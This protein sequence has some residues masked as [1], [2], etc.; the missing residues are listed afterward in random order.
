M[1]EHSHK[2]P[3]S[4]KVEYSRRRRIICSFSILLI[5][6]VSIAISYFFCHL[7][8]RIDRDTEILVCASLLYSVGF[9]VLI[10]PVMW[11]LRTFKPFPV[12]LLFCECFGLVLVL[13]AF[14]RHLISSLD[15]MAAS[16]PPAFAAFQSYVAAA[17]I[18]ECV[19]LM[20][21]AT[22]LVFY[23]RCRTVYNAIFFGC[24]SGVSF[25]TIENLIICH[26]G[27]AIAVQRFL[28]CTATHTSD[29]LVGILLFLYMKSADHPLVPDKWYFYPFVFILPVVFHGT[30]DFCIYYGQVTERS[31]VS[32]MSI[33]IGALSLTLCLGMFL[34]F[35][36]RKSTVV[37][38]SVLPTNV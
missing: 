11:Y 29:S 23:K 9:A 6:P 28:W 3:I 25:A 4:D 27:L 19:K 24:V 38:T 7:Y 18:E 31:W 22:P 35:R 5:F 8:K 15:D 16:D 2:W 20:V 1:E 10:I 17:C 33:L 12:M 36:R 21:F 37:K 26:K 14:K 30:F 13:V 34:P 32:A